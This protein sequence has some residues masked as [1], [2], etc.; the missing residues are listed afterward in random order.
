MQRLNFSDFG[1]KLTENSG[2]LQ[3][4]DD[5]GQPLPPGHSF[6][7]GGGNPARIPELD[8]MYQSEMAKIMAADDSFG[9]LIGRYDAPGGRVSFLDDIASCLSGKYGWNI[10]SENIAVTNGSQTAMFYLFNLFGG[11]STENGVAEKKTVVFPLVPEYIGYADQGIEKDMFVG[12]PALF[13]I[14]DDHTFKYSVDFLVLEK[15][16]AEHDN[17]GAL[18]VTRPTNPTGNVLT[19]D[20]ILHLSKLAVRYDI[21]LIIDNAY[22]LPWPDIIFTD[23]AGPFFSE[24]VILSMSMSK[25]GLPSMRTGIII[26][27]KEIAKAVSNINAI[28]SLTTA[29]AG[30]AIASSLIRSGKLLDC[31]KNIVRPFYEKRSKD[32]QTWIHKYFAGTNY[33]VHKSEGSIFLWLLLF[34]LKIPTKELY[35]QLKKCGVIVVPGEYFF[36]G[37]ASDGSFPPVKDHPHYDKCLRLNYSRPAEETEEG[38]RIISEVYR[39]YC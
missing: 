6:Q 14:F 21:P 1:K 8:E 37:D 38:I 26:A 16:L 30:Q 39:K 32:A 31:A 7:L 4:M 19:D 34:D 35:C 33:A 18:C 29:S 3:L 24:N 36:F 15:Y 27:Q 20:E 17:V 12:I 22:G 28:I 5:L 10:T 2:I 25:I 11:T 13:E 9:Q 23:S